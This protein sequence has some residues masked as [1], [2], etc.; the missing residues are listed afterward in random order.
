MKPL[1]RYTVGPSI[2]QGLE[3]LQE[4][5][6]KLLEVFKDTFDYLICYNGFKDISFLEAIVQ[7]TPVRL[8]EQNWENCPIVE[9]MSFV[10]SNGRFD[11]NGNQVKGSFWKVVPP[12]MRMDSHE[13]IMDNDMVL[14]DFFPQIKEF[15][16]SDKV[17]I[18]EEPIRFY[19]RY[20]K[21]FPENTS[22]NSGLMGLPPDYDFGGAIKKTWESNGSLTGLTQ[23]DEQGLLMATLNQEPNI[24]ISKNDVVEILARDFTKS[25][26]GLERGIHF[27]QSNKIQNHRAFIQYKKLRN[28]CQIT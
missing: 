5:V 26:T 21:L 13:I 8:Y 16:S 4:S 7:G 24:R 12:R 1:F 11:W 6:V 25:V 27:V 22:L 14:L 28:V 15:L 20:D 23:A 19:G 18:L 10:N 17:M 2:P 3:V 9:E